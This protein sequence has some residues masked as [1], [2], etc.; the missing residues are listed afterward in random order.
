[1]AGLHILCLFGLAVVGLSI[2]FIVEPEE[3]RCFKK[4]VEAGDYFAGDITV[5]GM[6]EDMVKVKV[7]NEKGFVHYLGENQIEHYFH[8]D[9]DHNTTI[10]VC[11]ESQDQYQKVISMSLKT[12]FEGYRLS[13]NEEHDHP[14]LKDLHDAHI[15]LLSIL[16]DQEGFQIRQTTHKNLVFQSEKHIRSTAAFKAIAIFFVVLIQVN[17]IMRFLRNAHTGPEV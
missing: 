14:V 8:V 16:T 2:N 4:H 15:N 6:N 9:A 7:R 17:V 10:E 13:I 3:P 5:S 1:M 11:I 12:Y